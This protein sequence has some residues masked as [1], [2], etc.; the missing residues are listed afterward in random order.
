M[1]KKRK[2]KHRTK[3]REIH[4]IN[5]KIQHYTNRSIELCH[6]LESSTNE[7]TK[8]AIRAQYDCVC[9]I[10]NGL[11]NDKINLTSHL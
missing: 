9:E 6:Q 5:R 10:V 1:S 7:H 4:D 8:I 3:D 2:R 11:I